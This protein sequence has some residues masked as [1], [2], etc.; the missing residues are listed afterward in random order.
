MN[1]A[2]VDHLIELFNQAPPKFLKFPLNEKG[3]EMENK[4]SG[5]IQFFFECI[6][7]KVGDDM[8]AILDVKSYLNQVLYHSKLCLAQNEEYRL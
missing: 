7:D 8:P 3:Q 6:T 2:D 1:E 4:L 5:L